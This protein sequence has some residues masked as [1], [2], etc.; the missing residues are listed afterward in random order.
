MD[1]FAD[2]SILI[3][4]H[5]CFMKSALGDLPRCRLLYSYWLVFHSNICLNLLSFKFL[6]TL[7]LTFQV[8]PRSNVVMLLD[9]PY[10]IS[11]L[12]FNSNIRPSVTP[13]R[14]INLNNLNDRDFHLSRSHKI[15]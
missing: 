1:G 12:V 9:S 8:L 13:L 15:I 2:V 11:L 4:E 14:D 5:R 10:M 3:N 6:V 7:T